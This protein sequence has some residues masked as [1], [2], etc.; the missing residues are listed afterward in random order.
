[1]KG[2]AQQQQPTPSASSS[3]ISPGKYPKDAG[4]L[5]NQGLNA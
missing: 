4:G 1:M 3:S 5:R 2:E